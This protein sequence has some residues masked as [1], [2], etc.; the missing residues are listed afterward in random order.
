MQ[1]M[2][3]P[4]VTA[5]APYGIVSFE[6]AGT[7]A[8]AQLILDSW[9]ARAKQYAAFGLGFDYLFMLAYSAAIGLGCLLA[10]G[11]I[12]G[13]GWPLASLGVLLA[14]GMW[15]AA[16]LDAVENF[17]LLQLLL[18]GTSNGGWPAVARLCAVLKF[19]LIFLGLVYVMYGL[20]TGLL[21]RLRR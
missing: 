1:I 20:A 2:G 15:L 13:R 4:L 3:K 11:V 7:P 5:Q 9:D 17:A 18:A 16:L 8:Q 10:A 21:A 14:W 6:L 19:G 12:R